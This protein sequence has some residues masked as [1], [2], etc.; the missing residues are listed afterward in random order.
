M[1]VEL[2][3]PVPAGQK[4]SVSKRLLVGMC[5]PMAYTLPDTND[6][7]YCI[8]TTSSGDYSALHILQAFHSIILIP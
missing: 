6:S 8:F 5:A 1:V 7:S 4:N 3:M 2:A